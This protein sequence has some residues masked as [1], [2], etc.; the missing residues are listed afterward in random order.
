[1]TSPLRILIIAILFAGSTNISFAQKTESTVLLISFD[2]FRHDYIDKHDLKNFKA[3]R[4]NGSSAEGLIPCY[5]SVTFPNHYSIVTG[6]RP[7]NHGL[8]DNSF[9]D[10]MLNVTYSIGN[11]DMVSNPKFYGGTPLWVLAKQAGIKTASYFWVGS[12][13][14]DPARRPDKYFLYDVKVDFKTRV[15]SVL[16]W[17]NMKDS[18]RPRFITLYFSEPDH[19][20]HETGPNSPETHDILLRMDSVLGYLVEG[21]KK[22]KTPVNTIVVSD[23]GMME[24]TVADETFT[25]L[26][27]LYDVHTTK[28]K[29]VVSSTI[30][31]L[32]FDQQPTLDSMY[33]LLKAKEK[34]FKVYKKAGLPKQLQYGNHYRIGDLVL[35][36]DPGHIFRHSDRTRNSQDMK[37]GSHFGVHGYDPTAVSEVR[38]IFLAQGPQV[39]KGQKLGLVRNIDVY[40]FVARI[41]GLTIPK[42]DGD[43]K[44]LEKIYGGK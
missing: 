41:L 14:T 36:S 38:G 30:A 32:Y 25:F 29:T 23:H 2:G 37:P 5:P 3:F 10:S 15:D 40:P 34:S 6:M 7:A 18:E 28:F 35:I 13:V 26:D 42:I 4:A 22:V 9:Y 11:R 44:A 20:A 17:L 43:P 27:E 33:T 21:V 24:L 8:V 12:E 16:S 19:V 39:K 1:M 31:H